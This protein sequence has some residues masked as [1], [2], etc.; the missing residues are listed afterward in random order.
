[1]IKTES[2]KRTMTSYYYDSYAIIEFLDKNQKYREYF[3]EHQGVLTILNL[4]EVSYSLQKHF[5]FKSTVEHLEPF[6]PFVV[7]FDL[8]D[9]DA[10]MKLR[11]ALERNEKLNISYVDALGYHLAKKYRVLFLTG[12]RHFKDLD[13]VEFVK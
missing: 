1:M 10:A 7:N 11:L 12:D 5:G 4:M 8:S 2:M 9:V 13:N 3:T 6:L